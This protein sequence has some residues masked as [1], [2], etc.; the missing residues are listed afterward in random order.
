MGNARIVEI[1]REWRVA[2]P[3]RSDSG[4]KTRTGEGE[5]KTQL[6]EQVSLRSVH[7]TIL[8]NNVE[9]DKGQSSQEHT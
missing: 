8:Y 4:G 6:L 7:Q 2:R 3:K 9:P 1:S 5:W